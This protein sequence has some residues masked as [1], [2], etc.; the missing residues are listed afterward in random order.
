MK[1]QKR[2]RGTH[3]VLGGV[4]WRVRRRVKLEIRME[5]LQESPELEGRQESTPIGGT[6]RAPAAKRSSSEGQL[7][8]KY[9][10][11]R[12]GLTRPE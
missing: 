8:Q 5:E 12:V 11:A 4:G 6:R 7:L 3:L 10:S 9:P 1:E 2:V